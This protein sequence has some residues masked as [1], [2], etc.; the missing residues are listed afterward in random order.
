MT[1]GAWRIQ[2]RVLLDEK[3]QLPHD[4]LLTTKTDASACYASGCRTKKCEKSDI[5][6]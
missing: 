4:P 2:G 1:K 5:A 3:H 6:Y